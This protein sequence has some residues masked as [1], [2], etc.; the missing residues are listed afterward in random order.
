[1]ADLGFCGIHPKI[2]II[3]E[4]EK[5][6]AAWVPELMAYLTIVTR[7]A[8]NTS[9]ILGHLEI[10]AGHRTFSHLLGHESHRLFIAS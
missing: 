1:M 6:V 10:T 2:L 9:G 8:R 3:A 5:R 4:L 7:P